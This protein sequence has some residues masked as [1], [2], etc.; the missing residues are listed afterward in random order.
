MGLLPTNALSCTAPV[1]PHAWPAQTTPAVP[2]PPTCK[3][4][5]PAWNQRP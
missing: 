1:H 2:G 4:T 5:N 3:P